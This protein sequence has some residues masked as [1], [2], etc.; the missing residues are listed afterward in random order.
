M[1]KLRDFSTSSLTSDLSKSLPLDPQAL[2][3]KLVYLSS[4]SGDLPS[5]W[6]NKCPTSSDFTLT[7]DLVIEDFTLQYADDTK[8]MFHSRNPHQNSGP[9][10]VACVCEVCS[11]ESKQ[12]GTT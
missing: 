6:T 10:P 9:H 12:R 1:S 3:R 7:A 4:L 5:Q 2:R 8:M 11:G